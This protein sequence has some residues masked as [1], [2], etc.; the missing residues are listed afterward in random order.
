MKQK[1]PKI[2]QKNLIKNPQKFTFRLIDFHING[3]LYAFK[4]SCSL[5]HYPYELKT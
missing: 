2:I 3:I 4:C 1:S 5:I